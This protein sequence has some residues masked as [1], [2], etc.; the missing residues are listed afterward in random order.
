MST[1]NPQLNKNMYHAD[2][3]YRVWGLG[4]QFQIPH[5]K[6]KEVQ[7]KKY[8][9]ALDCQPFSAPLCL[10]VKQLLSLLPEPFP[11]AV[12]PF[13]RFTVSSGQVIRPTHPR[14]THTRDLLL[15]SGVPGQSKAQK[16]APGLNRGP[17]SNEENKVCGS[18]GCY[19][20]S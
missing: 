3:R 19:L 18:G 15:G 13:L 16:S 14:S 1:R 6:E 12:S 4:R 2:F 7:K 5:S 9:S 11:F 20:V 10:S 17:M 8:T